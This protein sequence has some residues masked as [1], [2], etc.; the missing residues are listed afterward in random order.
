MNKVKKRQ[1]AL[2]EYPAIA[3]KLKDLNERNLAI[4]VAGIYKKE[5]LNKLSEKELLAKEHLDFIGEYSSIVSTSDKVFWLCMTQPHHVDSIKEYNGGGWAEFIVK[6]AIT[7]DVI[8]PAFERAEKSSKE[9]KWGRIDE[10]LTKMFNKDLAVTYVLD[11]RI[12]W[13]EKKKDWNSFIQYVQPHLAR[14]DLRKMGSDHLNSCAWYVFKYSN[15]TKL[16]KEAVKWIE[17]GIENTQEE[18]RWMALDTKACLLYKLGKREEGI[19]IMK[20]ITELYP[21][22][23]YA[24]QPRLDSMIKGE[25]IWLTFD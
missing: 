13:Y 22:F 6:R 8:Q 15:D 20:S 23:N 24:F 3:K 18:L 4:Q 5:Y 19:A 21:Q 7:R 12:D 25:S 16:L 17:T 1:I 11:A 14:H 9:P 10:L 2:A